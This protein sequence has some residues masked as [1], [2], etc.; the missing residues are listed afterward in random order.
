MENKVDGSINLMQSVL[1]EIAVQQRA[2]MDNGSG[3]ISEI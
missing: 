1:E 3:L 2:L